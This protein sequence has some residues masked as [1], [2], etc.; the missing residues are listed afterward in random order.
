M[1]CMYEVLFRASHSK[2]FPLHININSF[3][4]AFIQRW[5]R[6]PCKVPT[7][8][9]GVTQHF[10]PKRPTSILWIG[11]CSHSKCECEWVWNLRFGILPKN[12]QTGGARDWTTN[13]LNSGR[14]TLSSE[15][16]PYMFSLSSV[17]LSVQWLMNPPPAPSEITWNTE[18]SLSHG[19]HWICGPPTVDASSGK[20]CTH[21]TSYPVRIR[22]HAV[23]LISYSSATE[24]SILT[25][26]HKHIHFSLFCLT[27]MKE[28]LF[29]HHLLCHR[30]LAPWVVKI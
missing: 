22:G 19:P 16:L 3:T 27:P 12:M 30:G 28:I 13:L 20:P 8:L 7:C 6:L 17:C 11:F 15:P 18:N 1:D 14:P 4:H 26:T 9:S 2:C 24:A 29:M 25:H 5:Q 10:Q 21:H 23:A